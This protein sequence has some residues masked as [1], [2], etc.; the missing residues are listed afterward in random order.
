[1]KTRS[2]LAALMVAALL[3]PACTKH[4]IPATWGDGG[5]QNHGGNNPGGNGGQNPGGGDTPGGGGG[6]QQG[7]LT[8]NLRADWSIEYAGRIED[9][10]EFGDV[11]NVYVSCPGAE[12]YEVRILTPSELID[13]Y[14][15]DLKSYLEEEEGYI[16]QDAEAAGGFLNLV[17]SDVNP[18]GYV[19]TPSTTNILFDRSRSGE[20]IYILIGLNHEGKVTGDYAQTTVVIQQEVATAEYKKWLGEWLVSNGEVGYRIT[21]SQSES[22]WLY[23]VDGW[24]TGSSIASGGTVMDQEYIEARFD[25]KSGNMAFFSQFLGGYEDE[26]WG[27]LDEYFLG[28]Y[29]ETN[30]VWVITDTGK[31]IAIASMEEGSTSVAKLESAPLVITNAIGGQT[32]ISYYSMS[33]WNIDSQN[34]EP[35]WCQYNQNIPAFPLTMTK[36]KSSGLVQMAPEREVNGMTIHKN[37]PRDRRVS[38]G[39]TA[40][41][42]KGGMR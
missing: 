32:T 11:E 9:Y 28:Y 16:A 21:V 33:Y 37:Q 22:N 3:V 2:I 39:S 34:A 10:D 30:D 35:Q 31:D 6:G 4:R 19:H 25:R 36:T 26:Q 7:G 5:S 38:A 1:M 24:E 41:Y 17:W 42:S 13:N 27:W 12:Y 18:S 15:N 8:L 14:K 23:R 20:F 40:V 29:V